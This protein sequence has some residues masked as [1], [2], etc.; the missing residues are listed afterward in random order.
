[1]APAVPTTA[2]R[3]IKLIKDQKPFTDVNPS[4][5]DFTQYDPGLYNRSGELPGS[6]ANEAADVIRVRENATGEVTTPFVAVE[7][8]PEF[9]DGLAA[10]YKFINKHLR[11]PPQAQA[12]GL[13]GV[14]ILTFVVS[15]TGQISDIAILQDIG[16]GAAEE[17]IR[18]IQKMPDWRPG[19]Q[20]K[21]A[22]PVR[23]TLPVIFKLN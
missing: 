10:M 18:V 20:Y 15:S 9:P 11:Y 12:R 7:Q 8:M 22:V 5:R 6:A 4:Q 13:E 21:R 23:F 16:G 19:R 17:A 2:F 1:V 14:V 3:E